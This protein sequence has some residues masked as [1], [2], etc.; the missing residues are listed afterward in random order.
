MRAMTDLVRE[1]FDSF[2]SER[3]NGQRKSKGKDIGYHEILLRIFLNTVLILGMPRLLLKIQ[4][5]SSERNGK[6]SD[7]W[8]HCGTSRPIHSCMGAIHTESNEG[9]MRHM[10]PFWS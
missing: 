7:R 8:N 9:Q 6:S 10:R 1:F 2:R 4:Q 5:Q 3:Q